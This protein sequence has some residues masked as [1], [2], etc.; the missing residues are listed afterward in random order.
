MCD[1]AFLAAHVN[2]LTPETEAIGRARKNPFS[3]FPS[4]PFNAHASNIEYPAAYRAAER[5]TRGKW[6]SIKIEKFM[7]LIS[8][9]SHQDEETISHLLK[10]RKEIV[11]PTAEPKQ[12]DVVI[13]CMKEYLDTGWK[14]VNTSANVDSDIPDVFGAGG[15]KPDI[16]LYSPSMLPLEGRPTDMKKAEV[17]WKIKIG[18]TPFRDPPEEADEDDAETAA[19]E[20]NTEKIDTD[21]DGDG[22][23]EGDTYQVDA[24][25][26][27]AYEVEEY[28]DDAYGDNPAA[29]DTI[30]ELDSLNNFE[31]PAEKAA[32]IRGQITIYNAVIQSLQ[33]RTKGRPEA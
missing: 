5:E 10:T 24:Y 15:V 16:T 31:N 29:D 27:D 28:E 22:A 25:E 4:K 8:T 32:E 13:D 33:H 11:L 26:E 12:C 20:N 6:V 17:F 14:Q 1:A 30:E 7:E 23:D 21:G 2:T 19:D 18:V 3:S 9:C